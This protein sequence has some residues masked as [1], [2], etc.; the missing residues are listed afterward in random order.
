MSTNLSNQL[1]TEGLIDCFDAGNSKS[2][3][4]VSQKINSLSRAY[5]PQIT[6]ATSGHMSLSLPSSGFAILRN[7]TAFSEEKKGVLNLDGMN[8]YIQLNTSVTLS[9]LTYSI[10]YKPSSTDTHFRSLGQTGAWSTTEFACFCIGNH[11]P[12]IHQISL[13]IKSSNGTINTTLPGIINP[14]YYDTWHNA[15][16]VVEPSKQS[17]YYNGQLCESTTRT[18]NSDITINKLNIGNSM[19]YGFFGGKIGPTT[20]YNRVLSD[21]EIKHNYNALKS[22]FIS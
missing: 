6:I 9:H 3:I 19:G 22:R 5:K 10:W 13:R 17:I 16:F 15:T 20:L 12:Y 11:P 14:N 7:G 4:D 8:D 21:L 18:N 2:Y 1:I